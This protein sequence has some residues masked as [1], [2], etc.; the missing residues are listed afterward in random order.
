[1]LAVGA[2][3]IWPNIT[4]LL[5][6][7]FPKQRQP[8]VM[9]LIAATVGLGQALG[10]IVGGIIMHWLSWHWIFWLNVPISLLTLASVY[11]FKQTPPDN[12]QAVLPWFNSVLL[13]ISLGL[14]ALGI[15]EI[16]SAA[17]WHDHASTLLI[18]AFLGLASF[19]MTERLTQTP[20]IAPSLFKNGA[21][22]KACLL[23]VLSVIVIYTV[24]FVMGL[25]FQQHWRLSILQTSWYFL[26]MTIS[27]ASMSPLAGKLIARFSAQK[28][29][30]LAVSLSIAG[31]AWM[32]IAATGMH[33]Y[34]TIGPLILLGVGYAGAGPA[35][36]ILAVTAV[37]EKIKGAA[38]GVFYM[39]SLI[40]G[41]M[42]VAIDSGFIDNQHAQYITIA[43]LSHSF[44]LLVVTNFLAL[45]VLLFIKGHD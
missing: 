23:R 36:L 31:S 19:Y 44:G 33:P 8:F 27:M 38:T 3:L 9:S 35:V 5:L 30:A 18:F 20:L 7:I 16:P 1:M 15:N 25:F 22:L 37:N 32:I 34:A 13:T 43:T 11:S 28:V 26:A 42:I 40:S 45:V 6:N 12:N 39:V 24:L 29:L 10:P 2:A 4:V 21:F 41:L 14:L 17:Q